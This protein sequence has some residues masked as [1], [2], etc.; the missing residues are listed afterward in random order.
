[1]TGFRKYFVPQGWQLYMAYLK[2]TKVM[3]MVG[4]GG[5]TIGAI[6]TEVPEIVNKGATG[7]AYHWILRMPITISFFKKDQSGDSKTGPTGKFYLFM[8]I[9]RVAQGG[10][11]DGIAITNWRMMDVPKP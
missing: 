2:D 10:G 1:M 9:M 4:S 5:Y 3:D 6:V 11:D 7:G 8:D